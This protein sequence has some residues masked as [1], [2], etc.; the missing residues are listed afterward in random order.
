MAS[1]GSRESLINWRKLSRKCVL[2]NHLR[3]DQKEV[4]LGGGLVVWRYCF[5]AQIAKPSPKIFDACLP[6]N[7]S[8]ANE[9]TIRRGCHFD[10]DHDFLTQLVERTR[11]LKWGALAKMLDSFYRIH[12]LL[13]FDRLQL[14]TRQRLKVNETP[15]I[16]MTHSDSYSRLRSLVLSNPGQIYIVYYS[17]I[18]L[19]EGMCM[20][21]VK[22]SWDQ[23]L[24]T[25]IAAGYRGK[26]EQLCM[27]T[28][29]RIRSAYLRHESQDAENSASNQTERYYDMGWDVSILLD[30]SILVN[31]LPPR[32]WDLAQHVVRTG[33]CPVLCAYS[34][35]WR[36]IDFNIK[37]TRYSY[38][39]RNYWIKIKN[40]FR[41]MREKLIFWQ[42]IE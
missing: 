12:T 22:Q 40:I 25:K 37:F 41:I 36:K 19:Y 28:I 33:T 2:E 1:T 38:K 8:S 39:I 5:D 15:L 16:F 29:V 24:R 27:S 7:K 14:Q 6:R 18:A 26:S 17:A 3:L 13:T 32:S 23:D 34:W 11:S 21:T 31:L 9:K 42:N 4:F 10:D 20:L 35:F 30:Q